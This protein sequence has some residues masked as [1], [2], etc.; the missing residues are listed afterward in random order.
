VCGTN[1]ECIYDYYVTGDENLGQISANFSD[2][3]D[4]ITNITAAGKYIL[5]VRRV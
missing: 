2:Q 3:F 4:V 1:Y 5:N